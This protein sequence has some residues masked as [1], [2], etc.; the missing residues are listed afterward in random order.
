AIDCSTKESICIVFENRAKETLIPLILKYIKKG[1]IIVS[2]A[3]AS[4]LTISL[5]GY[6]HFIV[7]FLK[8]CGY[9]FR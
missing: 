2:D 9:I 6:E 4:Y 1:S 3:W 8:F 7:N 5:Y